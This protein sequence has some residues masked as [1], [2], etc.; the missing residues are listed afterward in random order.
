MPEP[1]R[2]V[3]GI[4]R[5]PERKVFKAPE[6]P[7]VAKSARIEG[8][9]VLEATLDERGVVQNVTVLRSVPLL[10]QAAI[11][12]VRQWRYSPTRLNGVAI[13]II[14]T[15]TVTFSIR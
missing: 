12:A 3:G 5:P 6:Y 13:S 15:V 1:P 7:P 2:R 9:V 4:V 11:D 8:T 14:M 10:D